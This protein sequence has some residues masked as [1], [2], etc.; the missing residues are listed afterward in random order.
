MQVKV[1]FYATEKK[2]ATMGEGYYYPPH[3]TKM[4]IKMD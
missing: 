4:E 1:I 3:Q 2:I